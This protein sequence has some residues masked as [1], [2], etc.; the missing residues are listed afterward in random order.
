[1]TSDPA[2]VEILTSFIAGT[3]SRVP[4]AYTASCCRPIVDIT[5]TDARGNFLN[6]R[7]DANAGTSTLYAQTATTYAVC[8]FTLIIVHGQVA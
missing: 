5:A 3:T 6:Q 8:V 7:I 1:V 4:I 2:G